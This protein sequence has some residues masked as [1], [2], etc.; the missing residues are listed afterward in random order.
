MRGMIILLFRLYIS[1]IC[2][3]NVHVSL[4]EST[5]KAL[6]DLAYL[7]YFGH[8]R[9]KYDIFTEKVSPLESFW[10]FNRN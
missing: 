5:H 2:E 6:G 10:L 8:F 9:A 3:V 4:G 1:V 7:C